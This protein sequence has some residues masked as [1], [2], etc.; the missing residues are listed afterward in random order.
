MQRRAKGLAEGEKLVPLGSREPRTGSEV[1]AHLG[2]IYGRY[3]RAIY[4]FFFRK[5]VPPDL[6]TELTQETFLALVKGAD[7]FDVRFG[8]FRAWLFSVAHNVYKQE[9]RRQAALK[10]EAAEVSWDELASYAPWEGQSVVIAPERDPLHEVLAREQ[11][12]VFRRAL[13]SLPDQMRRCVLLRV[14]GDLRYREIADILQVSI[15]TV[16]AHLYQARQQLKGKL[17]SYFGDFEF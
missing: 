12:E 14:D 10:R 16:K 11:S 15:D 3:H 7:S 5:R 1:E 4:A 9:V 17:E 8:S 2:E 13:D 6:A